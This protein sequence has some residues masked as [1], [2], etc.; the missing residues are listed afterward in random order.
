MLFRNKCTPY[1]G[2]KLRGVVKETLLRGKSVFT[3]EA[4]FN[5][6]VGPLGQLLL[7]PRT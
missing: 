1:E 2:K 4:G 6:K 3:R 5:E 7:E